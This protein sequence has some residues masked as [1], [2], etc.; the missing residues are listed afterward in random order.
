VQVKSPPGEPR[1]AVR[2]RPEQLTDLGFRPVEVLDAVQTAF[3][4]SVVAQVYRENQVCDVAVMLDPA[5]RQDL[6][7]SA[8]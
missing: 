2:L 8:R 4:G 6:A 7:A 3:Q 5:A 1:I